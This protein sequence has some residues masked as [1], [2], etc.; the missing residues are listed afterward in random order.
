MKTYKKNWFFKNFSKLIDK[1]IFLFLHNG[2][3]EKR[4]VKIKNVTR[5]VG[6]RFVI[7]YENIV[8]ENK[9]EKGKSTIYIKSDEIKIFE[10]EDLGLAYSLL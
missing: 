9:G 5:I 8:G 4:L 10:E 6:D 3:S 1:Y 7:Q 2:S